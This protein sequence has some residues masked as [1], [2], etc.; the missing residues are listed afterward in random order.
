[1][2]ADVLVVILAAVAAVEF[3]A[4]IVLNVRF[5]RSRRRLEA[6]K[7]AMSSARTAPRSVAGRAVKAVVETAVRVRDQG[8]GGMLLSSLDDLTRWTTEDRSEIARIAA[9]DGTVTIF[10]S[11]IEGST[12]LNEQLGDDQ[13]VRVLDAHNGLIR[14]S[15]EKFGGHV[16]KS[17]GDG[18]MVVFG[19]PKQA[20]RAAS[21]IQTSLATTGS[22][23]LRRAEIA[24]RIG[25]HVGTVVS[26]EGDYFGRNVAMAARV[27][28]QAQGSEILISEECRQGLGDTD[29]FVLSE[30]GEIELKGLADRHLLWLVQWAA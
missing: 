29:E 17:Q 25:V 7:Q 15:V 21:R 16:V 26:R 18:F 14:S 20:V 24:V 27:A 8:V 5:T 28:S 3:V 12:N 1:M 30:F 13:W 19:D 11:D 4:L 10:F 23:R 6:L 9:P 2:S 22:R